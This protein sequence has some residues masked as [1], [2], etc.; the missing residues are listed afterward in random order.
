MG[1]GLYRERPQLCFFTG[2][3]AVKR[4]Y[5]HLYKGDKLI[6][7]TGTKIEDLELVDFKHDFVPHGID[8]KQ[9]DKDHWLLFAV[10]HRSDQDY[11]EMFDWYTAGNSLKLNHYGSVS[12]TQLGI[13]GQINDVTIIS[14]T[15]F[16]VTNDKFYNA[17]IGRI[18][19]YLG[20]PVGKLVFY[21]DGKATDVSRG[22]VEANGVSTSPSGERLFFTDLMS[23]VFYE[24]KIN[25]TDG[26]LT[27]LNSLFMPTSP[28]NIN[29][30][31]E[32]EM[33]IG[34][35]V[36]LH[37]L[38]IYF[39]DMENLKTASHLIRVYRKDINS[40]W[41]YETILMD[42]GSIVKGSSVGVY[43]HGNLYMGTVIE[44]IA[45]CTK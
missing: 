14:R 11:V 31:S 16:Y 37:D 36:R 20:L 23:N 3:D 35:H 24:F 26:S 29:V 30:I 22:Y 38:F 2:L 34:C 1:R 21:K 43:S 7:I 9:I 4:N 10:N 13:S 8:L 42:D 40:P 12:V 6:K 18:S 25:P 5:P 39:A 19:Q 27:L 45:Y 32:N 15:S 41:Q 28:D 17:V 33:L 44:K